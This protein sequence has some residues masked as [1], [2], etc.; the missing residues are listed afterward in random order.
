MNSI[1]SIVIPL[2]NVGRFVVPCIRSILQQSFR[3]YECIIVNDGSTDGCEILVRE[4]INGD[5]RFRLINQTNQG[6]AAARN[7]G[8]SEASGEY[9]WFVDADDILDPEALF[10]INKAIKENQHSDAVA[11]RVEH[12]SASFSLNDVLVQANKRGNVE[13]KNYDLC[14]GIGY[15]TLYRR[16]ELFYVVSI[17]T[18]RTIA[19]RFPFRSFRLLEDL[20]WRDELI[21]RGLSNIV[22]LNVQLYY[23]VSRPDSAV[24]MHRSISD[25]MRFCDAYDV[26]FSIIPTRSKVIARYA[27]HRFVSEIVN[28]PL[29]LNL[30]WYCGDAFRRGINKYLDLFGKLVLRDGADLSYIMTYRLIRLAP[31]K[32]LLKMLVLWQAKIRKWIV[33]RRRFFRGR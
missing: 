2:Y 26:Y 3:E 20:I 21:V 28:G 7:R 22:E 9:V 24:R 25:F 4:L 13:T 18:R 11:F 16:R 32:V 31:C 30:S 12:V 10:I 8:I 27:N 6:V 23:Y 14:E 29:P 19:V 5:A 1:F 15:E 33:D 17:V